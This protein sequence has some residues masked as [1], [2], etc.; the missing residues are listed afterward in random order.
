MLKKIFVILTI[1]VACALLNACG[2]TDT[3]AN[4]GNANNAN[5]ANNTNKGTTTASPAAS[6]AASTTTASAEK[7]GIAECDDFLAKYEACIAKVPEAG[8]SAYKTSMEQ[9]RD[10]WRKMAANP[11]TKAGLTQ[12]CKTQMENSKQTLKAIGCDF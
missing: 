1:C 9:W 5:N 12:V 4:N 6:P 2:G 11:T 8:R 7:I 10:S 3:N